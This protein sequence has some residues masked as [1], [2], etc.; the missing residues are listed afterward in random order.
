MLDDS[1][2][3]DEIAEELEGLTSQ[4]KVQATKR[5]LLEQKLE[6]TQSFLQGFSHKR[7]KED[8]RCYAED[9][10]K[11]IGDPYATP[12][13]VPDSETTFEL[14]RTIGRIEGR[15]LKLLASRLFSYDEDE[16]QGYTH[17][18]LY[19]KIQTLYEEVR[20]ILEEFENL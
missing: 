18:Q 14:A 5:R 11:P 6:S 15:F 17:E 9:D 1:N 19:T 10:E 16:L 7:Q 8:K 3:L 2:R 13:G 20:E 12:D 4:V